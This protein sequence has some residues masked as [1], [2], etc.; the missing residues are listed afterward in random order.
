MLLFTRS[1]ILR[2]ADGEVVL[3]TSEEFELLD[4]AI[5][6]CPSFNSHVSLGI[7][8]AN[9]FRITLTAATTSRAH[10]GV[11]PSLRNGLK[12]PHRRRRRLCLIGH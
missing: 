11:V 12:V 1:L 9:E 7:F 6:S 10:H 3:L 4:L 2:A 8:P 5:R